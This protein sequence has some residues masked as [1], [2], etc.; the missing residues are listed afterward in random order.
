MT[1]FQPPLDDRLA[2]DLSALFRRVAMLEQQVAQ[3]AGAYAAFA[4]TSATRPATPFPG[5]EI[6]ETDTGATAVWTGTAWLHGAVQIGPTQTLGAPAGPVTFSGIPPSV[7]SLVLLFQVQSAGTA[8]ARELLLAQINGDTNSAHYDGQQLEGVATSVS[9]S[10]SAQSG[11]QI[12]DVPQSGAAGFSASQYS[13]GLAV[14]PGWGNSS[15][16]ASAV[17]M[18]YAGT[19]TVGLVGTYGGSFLVT[20]ARTSLTLRLGVSNMSAGS[21]FSLYGLM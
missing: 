5:L 21:T 15:A 13:A 1:T 14:F 10:T 12:G 17:S 7:T 18:Q 19:T 16:Y 11:I 6:F 3:A 4:C 20:G 9:T 2:A 8:N